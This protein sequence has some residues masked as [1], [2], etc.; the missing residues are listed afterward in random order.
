MKRII[1]ALAFAGLLLGSCAPKVEDKVMA[2]HVPERMDDFVWE[3]DLIAGRAYGKALEGNPLSPGLDIW[4]KMPGKLVADSW[5]AAALED[6]EYYHRD[7]GGKD[8]YKVAKSLGGGASSPLV[9]SAFA[10]PATNWREYKIIEKTPEKVVFELVYP[11]W[12]VQ[13]LVPSKEG[14]P[15]MVSLVKRFT[16]EAG[17]YFVKVEDTYSGNFEEICIAA[18]LWKH[19]GALEKFSEMRD[20]KGVIAIWENA[21]DQSVEPEEGKLGIGVIMQD[22]DSIEIDGPADHAVALKTVKPSETITYWF[23]SCWSKADIKTAQE[24]FGL[25]SGK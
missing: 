8:C 4:V 16:V 7:N 11:A 19:G 1:I 3:N 23:G 25:C 17:T 9:D 14:E 2:R 20:G 5:Y 12:E 15:V 13:G 10:Y 6:P 21:S 18:G 22:A 24:W